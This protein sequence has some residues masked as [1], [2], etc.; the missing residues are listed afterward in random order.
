MKILYTS[1]PLTLYDYVNY[2]QFVA[3]FDMACK[4]IQ[5]VSVPKF[6]VI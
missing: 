5:R 6:E 1:G 2:N 4:T 3:N